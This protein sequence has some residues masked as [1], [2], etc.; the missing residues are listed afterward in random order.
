MHLALRPYVTTGVALVGASVIAAAPLRPVVPAEIQIPNPAVQAVERGVQLTANEIE[1]AVNQLVFAAT[2]AGVSVA[3]L[4]TPLVAQ[5]LG[6]SETEA[7]QFLALGTIGLFGPLISGTGAVGTALQDIVDSDGLEELLINLIGAPGTI[8]DGVVNGG[9]GP[10]LLPLVPFLS[11]LP[12]PPVTG[13]FAPGLIQNAGFTYLSALQGIGFKIGAGPTTTLLPPGTIAVLQGLVERLFGLFSPAA[14][15]N[16]QSVSALAAPAPDSTIEDGINSLLF[17]LTKATLSVVTLAAPLVAPI[18]GVS[19]PQAEAFLA[20]GTVGLLGPVISG[21]GAV[22]A[23][24]QDIV[25]SDG[26]EGLLTSLIGAPGTVADGV[27]NGGYGPNLLPLLPALAALPLPVNGAFAPGLISN[28]GYTYLAAL[29]GIG[30][31]PN[32]TGVSVLPPSTTAVLQ[33]LVE[34]VFGALPSAA[35]LNTSTFKAPG[36]RTK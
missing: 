11:A 28:P 31:K 34:R 29:Q 2:K 19:E 4:T 36:R 18:L 20:L 30:F 1:N 7:A 26:V 17:V 21:T 33:G 16:V 3:K 12:L 27:V 24:L 6:I 35:S 22:G 13:V 9:Y 14:S 25:N 10:N 32:A 15:M 5:I 23:A 8:T